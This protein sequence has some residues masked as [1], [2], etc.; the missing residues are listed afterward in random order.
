M[1]RLLVVAGGGGGTANNGY[2][3][4]DLAGGA[5]GGSGHVDGRAGQDGGVPG[6]G[7]GGG[8]TTEGGTGGT[9]SGCIPLGTASGQLQGG[10]APSGMIHAG[11]C[12]AGGGGGS[13]YFGGGGGGSGGGG[14]GSG[15]PAAA[16]VADGITITPDTADTST[17]T[18][19]GVVTI[20]YPAAAPACPIVSGYR[21]TLC[22]ADSGDSAANDT[23]ISIATCDASPGQN[24]TVTSS[25]TLQ[26]NGKCLDIYRDEKTSK[27]PVELWTCTGGANQQWHAT[28]A[29]H[30]S[31]RSPANA[32][33]TPGSAPPPA[34]SWSSTPATAA[35]TS[36]GNS[37]EPAHL[38]LQQDPPHSTPDTT[39]RA[40]APPRC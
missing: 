12:D 23:P 14:G 18:G 32:S 30:W 29:G 22:A 39:A 5:G 6:G 28:A 15:F 24:W 25:G 16:T 36:N 2:F 21:A 27:A 35:P 17:N 4:T 26:V 40:R 8:T 37:P 13:G 7:G 38:Q 19:N 1:A 11:S 3:Q 9:E 10:D 34:P 20:S 31:T 33:T